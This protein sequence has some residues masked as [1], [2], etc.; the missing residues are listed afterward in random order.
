[1]MALIW[2]Y[3]AGVP[4]FFDGDFALTEIVLTGLIALFC[5][6]GLLACTRIGSTTSIANRLLAVA[7][8]GTFQFA[9]MWVSFLQPFVNR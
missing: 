7:V 5:A 2:L 4:M 9:A 1:M 8:F 3:L 6:L